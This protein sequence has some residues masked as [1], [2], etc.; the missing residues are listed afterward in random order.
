[1]RIAVW[2][3]VTLAG[4][5][6]TRRSLQEDDGGTG[7]IGQDAAGNPF[8]QI[9][10]GLGRIDTQPAPADALSP[11]VD[12]GRNCGVSTIKG[13]HVPTDILLILDRSITGDQAAWRN[14]ISAI[15]DVM[16]ANGARFDWG[17]SVFPK[18][19][20]ACGAATVST[21]ADLGFG[22]GA[23]WHVIAHLTEAG[24]DGNGTPTAA[25]I[26]AGAAYLSTV[27]DGR[28]KFMMLVTDG[29]PTCAGTADA[30]VNDAAQALADAVAASAAALAA[31]TPLFVV[32]AGATTARDVD[33]LN[34]LA[35]AGGYPRANPNEFYPTSSVDELIQT[36]TPSSSYTCVLS[37]AKAPPDTYVVTV[38]VNGAVFVRDTTHQNGW[39]YTDSTH[40][41]LTLYGA[42]CELIPISWDL[43]VQ[44][45]FACTLPTGA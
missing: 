26:G 38:T 42:A 39:D 17:L 34:K 27:M 4:V 20:P 29:A 8:Q 18:D 21:G 22:L 31:G 6:C 24:V 43:E 16:N 9:D 28:P 40:S 32:G 30:P 36:L 11:P 35:R 41:T 15:V 5:A 44:I 23:T 25:A 7:S 3:L 45:T 1:M 33:A 12:G 14:L 37:L 2:A 10:G 13:N 19:G